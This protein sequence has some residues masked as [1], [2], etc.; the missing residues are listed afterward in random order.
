MHLFVGSIVLPVRL[1]NNG[2]CWCF[3]PA[4]FLLLSTQSHAHLPKPIHSNCH[5]LNGSRLNEAVLSIE[6]HFR[7]V[8]VS[9][10]SPRENKENRTA[11]RARERH[12]PHRYS[13]V[14]KC[15]SIVERKTVTRNDDNA[16]SRAALS[17]AQSARSSTGEVHWYRTYGDDKVG[18]G[19]ASTSR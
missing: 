5:Y 10:T 9:K 14:K 13:N 17:R 7:R 8:S 16:D 3:S 6:V 1:N 4:H 19:H 11:Y 2:V 18:V 15:K 12:T